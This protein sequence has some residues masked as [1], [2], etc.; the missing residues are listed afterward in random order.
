MTIIVISLADNFSMFSWRRYPS[1]SDYV[2]VYLTTTTYMY[3]Q[4]MVS[5]SC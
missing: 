3:C 1:Y 2:H 5:P 4:I